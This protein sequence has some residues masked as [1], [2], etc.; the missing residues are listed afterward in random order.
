MGQNKQDRVVVRGGHAKITAC[1]A[2]EDQLYG[3]PLKVKELLSQHRG[4]DK[5]YG[6][7]NV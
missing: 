1:S 2:G 4:I 3:L 5:L 7:Y 6:E